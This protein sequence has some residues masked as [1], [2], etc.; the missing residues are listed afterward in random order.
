MSDDLTVRDLRRVLNVVWE[1]NE[2]GPDAGAAGLASLG[3]LV[4]CEA[5]A[6]GRMEPRTGRTSV[7]TS[8]PPGFIPAEVSGSCPEVHQHPGFIAYRAGRVARGSSVALTDLGETRAFRRTPLYASLYEPHGITDELLCAVRVDPH[9]DT[10][11]TIGR[12]R[13]GFS[14]RDRA[15]I[16][17]ISPH[18]AQSLARQ[19]RHVG[20]TAGAWSLLTAREQQVTTHIMRG[21]TDREIARAL[22]I[23]PRTVHKHV[24]H[25][26]RK[27]D[28][29][30]RTGLIALLSLPDAGGRDAPD[31]EPLAQQETEEHREQ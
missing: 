21:A 22:T 13:D 17:L 11:L 1:L 29:T 23:S 15:L 4:G 27:L 12:A 16:S 8:D 20:G 28:L 9:Q 30:N 18:F 19:H 6:C 5:I 14:R 25:I 26:Y 7:V 10:V 24:E 31:Q 3:R 2:D